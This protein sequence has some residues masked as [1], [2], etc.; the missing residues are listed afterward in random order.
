MTLLMSRGGIPDVFRDTITTTGREHNLP[1]NAFAI[2]A[3]NKGANVVRMYFTQADFN[4]DAKFVEL[5]VAAAAEPHGEWE[6]PVE[7]EKIFLRGVGGSS[8]VEVV[9]FQRRG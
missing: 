9:A 1:F 4:A 5:P 3:R 2:K 8:A 6:G 7:A